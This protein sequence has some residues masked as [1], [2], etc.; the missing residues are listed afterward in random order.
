MVSERKYKENILTLNMIYL[1]LNIYYWMSFEINDP[2]LDICGPGH[3]IL[4]SGHGIC[5]PEHGTFDFGHN[6]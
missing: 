6:T 4:D 2:E 1:T 3:N 5:G